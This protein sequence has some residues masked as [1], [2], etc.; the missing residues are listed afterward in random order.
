[1]PN[2]QLKPVS[3]SP[4][5][6]AESLRASAVR[7]TE[8]ANGN[9]ILRFQETHKETINDEGGGMEEDATTVRVENA[10][11]K[12]LLEQ[13]RV[14]LEQLDRSAEQWRLR[15]QEYESLLEEKSELIRQ[16]HVQLSER[17]A[18]KA[19]TDEAVP[20]EEELI[21]LHEELQREREQL[22]M[23]E[24]TL[25]AQVRDME[26][27]MSKERA[28]LARQRA[29]LTRLENELKHQ[30]DLATRDATMRDRLGPL[31]KLQ[32]DLMRRR[33]HSTK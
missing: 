31:Y 24:E 11:L 1:M 17:P 12:Q 32:E 21:A 3:R 5:A 25:M 29:D 33:P 6:L 16:L 18:A 15:E 23:D 7:D 22:K 10:R 26:I 14:R 20:T 27:Q 8:H 30:M 28:H 19:A 4:H 9:G 2:P 13:A